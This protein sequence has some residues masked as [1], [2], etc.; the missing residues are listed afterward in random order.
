MTD[1]QPSPV[2]PTTR[3]AE[4]GPHAARMDQPLVSFRLVEPAGRSAP[5][6]P[7]F[8]F[9]GA[10]AATARAI[11]GQIETPETG[12][13]AV[14][15]AAIAPTGI[16]LCDG[17]A[18]CGAQLNLP[19]AHVATITARLSTAD[20]PVRH[21][22]G[23]LV[24][25]FGPAEEAYGQM[26]VDYL[27][28]LWLLEQAGY[29]LATLRFLL[30]AAL[31]ARS[32]ALVAQL[33]LPADQVIRY[34]HWE[35]VIRTDLLVLPTILRKHE[36]LSAGFGPATRFWTQR[37]QA[38]LGVPAPSPRERV[39]IA[40]PD[41]RTRAEAVAQGAGF[42]VLVAGAALAERVQAFGA[43]SQIVGASG[44]ALHD[45]VFCAAG[46]RVCALGAGFLQTSIGA[47]LGLETGYVFGEDEAELCRG[48]D[49]LGL[50]RL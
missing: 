30:P 26:L 19:Q 15:N 3:I 2:P 46:A 23:P 48:L 10:D 29:D 35:E 16:A 33:G 18:F 13:Y 11:Y 25:L 24:P 21:V 31:P 40:G 14:A 20:L 43:A 4:I 44:D 50:G 12:C 41:G 38:G 22:P 42:R 36:R 28:R 17:V 39:F 45:S 5:P 27:P 7:A 8:L 49:V 37:V 1:A 6:A 34:A 32:E 47:A 9:G